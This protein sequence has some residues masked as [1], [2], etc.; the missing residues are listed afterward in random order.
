VTG[1]NQQLIADLARLAT[2]YAPEDWEILLEGLEDE[3]RRA[4]IVALLQELAA[5]SRVRPRKA[6]RDSDHRAR[7]PRVRDALA[8]ARVEDPA[9]A[10]RLEEAWA[11]LRRR[12]LLPDMRSIRAFAEAAGLKGIT[13]AKREQAINEVMELLIGLPTEALERMLQSPVVY[14]RASGDEYER[15]VHLILGRDES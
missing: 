5:T 1:L 7:L 10:E 2:R 8:K 9:R 12:E 14:D 4:Q 3:K 13:S 6:T 15:W 11:R